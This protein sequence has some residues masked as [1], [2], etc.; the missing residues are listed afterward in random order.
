MAKRFFLHVLWPFFTQEVSGPPTWLRFSPEASPKNFK[1]GLHF[2]YV[3]LDF[4]QEL[5]EPIEPTVGDLVRYFL[6]GN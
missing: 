4:S 1:K 5:F 6:G 3:Q 2:E